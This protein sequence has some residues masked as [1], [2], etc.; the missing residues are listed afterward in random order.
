LVNVVVPADPADSERPVLP[1]DGAPNCELLAPGTCAE[2]LVDEYRVVKSADKDLAKP[3]ETVAYTLTFTNLGAAPASV[4]TTDWLAAV[5]DDADLT[6]GPTSD[7]ASLTATFDRAEQAVKIAGQVPAP[8]GTEAVVAYQVTVREFAARADHSL[9]NLV[10][11]DDPPDGGF[12]CP[13]GDPSCTTTQVD[14]YR[15]VKTVDRD[16]AS[17][18]DVVA[19]TLAFVNQ[20]AAPARVDAVDSLSGVLD[21]ADLTAEPVSDSEGLTAVFNPEAQTIAVKGQIPAGAGAQA[22]VTYQVTVKPFEDR[23]DHLLANAVLTDPD[24]PPPPE[25][26]EQD[27]SCTVTPVEEMYVA[28]AVDALQLRLGEVAAFSVVF[29]NRGQTELYLNHHD[30]LGWVLDDGELIGEPTADHPS[31]SATWAPEPQRIE[32]Y[33]ALQPGESATIAYLAKVTKQGDLWYHNYVVDAFEPYAAN[34]YSPAEAAEPPECKPEEGMICTVTPIIPPDATPV[35]PLTGSAE[36]VPFALGALGL[37]ALGVW[38]IVWRRRRS[39][40]SAG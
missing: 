28:K 21:D 10:S 38:L 9:D 19:Y 7:T 39:P 30:L 36:A 11:A 27:L 29:A 16:V 17:P 1:A 33:G 12:D 18:G 31:V 3:G 13:A 25:C 14:D 34:P 24:Q 6:G 23:G 37:V 2:A 15:V 40:G 32:V 5:L 20:G 35:L 4:E 22:R 26:L 8:F